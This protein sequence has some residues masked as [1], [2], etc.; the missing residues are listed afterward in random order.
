[1]PDRGEI[2]GKLSCGWCE[3]L[4]A[5]AEGELLCGGNDEATKQMQV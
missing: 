5:K 1:M 3:G 2:E 4:R